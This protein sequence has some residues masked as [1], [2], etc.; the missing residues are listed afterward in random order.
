MSYLEPGSAVG[1]RY[2]VE[3]QIAKGGMAVVYRV[4][5]VE[6]G[7]LHAL[8][9][10]STTGDDVR[11]RL[12][13]EGRVQARLRHPNIVSVTDVVDV[14]G[15][16]GLVMEH[17]E[18]P[19]LHAW[20]QQHTPTLAESL[21]LFRSIVSGVHAAHAH[22]LI[23]RDLKP[24]NIL[25][26][27]RSEGLVAM[28]T[29]FGLAR[30]TEREPESGIDTRDGVPIGTPSF[31]A[32]E[33]IH[34]ARNADERA[35]IWALGGILYFLVAGKTA[36]YGRSA[37]EIMQRV[38][39]AEYDR[40]EVIDPRV[41]HGVR[42]LIDRCLQVDPAARFQRCEDLLI[43]L[44]LTAIPPVP[45]PA[46]SPGARIRPWVALASALAFAALGALSLVL[47]AAIGAVVWRGSAPTE[48]PSEPALPIAEPAAPEATP[49]PP[50]IGAT[51]CPLETGRIGYIDGS[52]V[53]RR[54][55]GEVWTLPDGRAIHPDFDASSV[56]IC[57]LP[58]GTAITLRDAPVRVRGGGMWVAVDSDGFRLP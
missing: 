46:A 17:I 20:R 15:L 38:N 51:G 56:V 30:A 44:E 13:Q 58:A 29:D 12:L 28:V 10:L 7:S 39:A 47:F 43:H 22:G 23:H 1:G 41:P 18:G 48:R 9:V 42:E 24:A 53:G 45:A 31:M 19:D 54:R 36:F 11:Q 49:D 34:D 50:P 6:L 25:L 14:S 8:K 5:H 16:P 35:D 26:D 32:P 40:I 55:V 52:N 27:R 4:R 57:R 33:Q 2:T 3:E 21:D 37:F